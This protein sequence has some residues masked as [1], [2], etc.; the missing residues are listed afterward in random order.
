MEYKITD[1]Q[2]FKL[3]NKILDYIEE[4]IDLD[5]FRLEEGGVGGYEGIYELTDDDDT[6]FVIYTQE[7]WSD[8][9]QEGRDRIKNSPILKVG[10]DFER[11]LNKMFGNNLWQD[12]L[13]K[14]I[15]YNFNIEIK[16]I[17]F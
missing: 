10:K 5:K 11:H 2:Y 9:T 3:Q 15:K 4:Y 16:K 13:K 12:A 7:Y 8:D 17:D 14:F 1:L 6:L